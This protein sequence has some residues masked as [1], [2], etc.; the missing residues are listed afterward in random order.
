MAAT[1]DSL[2]VYLGLDPASTVDEEAMGAAVAAAN[3]AAMYWR[4]DVTTDPGDGT[5]LPTW[6][7]DID[8]GAHI[9]AA[10]WYGRR[11]SVGGSVA[12]ADLGIASLPRLDPDVRF[13]WRLGEY[14]RSV[15]A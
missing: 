3:A 5:M 10:R 4:A 7:A 8:Q 12:Y 6:P 15:I 1:V 14:Q 13:L 9:Q 2:R 11:G